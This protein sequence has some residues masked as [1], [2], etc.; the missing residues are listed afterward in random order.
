MTMRLN[1][2]IIKLG[3]GL[4]GV[5]FGFGVCF[6][7]VSQDLGS[8]GSC[9]Y[10]CKVEVSVE[11]IVENEDGFKD[12][13]FGDELFVEIKTLKLFGV[14]G[15][16]IDG[17]FRPYAAVNRAE[18]LKMI[19]GSLGV[20]GVSGDSG[21]LDVKKDDWFAGFV[22]AGVDKGIVKGNPDGTFRPASNVNMAEFLKMSFGGFEKLDGQVKN[23]FE[24]IGGNGKIEFND[25]KKDD[26]FAKEFGLAGEL[27]ILRADKFGKG[28]PQLNLNRGEVARIIF[29]LKVLSHQD[30]KDLMLNL[31][32]SFL[33]QMSHF[34]KSGQIINAKAASEKAVM[35]SQFVLKNFGED[36]KVLGAAKIAK[37]F[38][39]L[40]NGY[41]AGASGRKEEALDWMGQAWRK[42]DEALESDGGLSMVVEKIK[43]EINMMKVSLK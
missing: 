11:K 27:G 16:Y 35:V 5:V 7:L 2:K 41:L 12:L 30:D 20:S 22:K 39:L 43:A 23:E 29:W 28:N 40:M 4:S 37:S 38:D 33:S 15:G 21:F 24:R 6:G 19:L 32:E 31:T 8:D 36:K 9:V 42:S 14:V 13:S 25:V 17:S 1:K 26:W 18:A 10:G 34:V 3:L